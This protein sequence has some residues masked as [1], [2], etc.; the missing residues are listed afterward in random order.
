MGKKAFR[1]EQQ[2]LQDPAIPIN[3]ACLI[4]GDAYSWEYVEKLYSMLCR[5]S[6]RLI[7]LHVYTEAHRDVPAPFIKHSLVD[8]NI[9]GP[10]K[11][12][13]YKLQLFNTDF[14]SGPLLYFD[15]DTVLT[16]SIDWIWQLNLRYFWAVR[17]FKYLWRSNSTG[18]NSSVMWWDTRQY[19]FIWENVASQEL[20]SLMLRH[21]GDQ[22]FI[23]EIVPYDQR[24]FFNTDWVKSWRWECLDGGFNFQ[25]R[26]HR[27]PG[28][29]TSIGTDTSIMIFHGKPKPKD[30]LDPV[31]LAHWQ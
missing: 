15:L 22:D 6:T 28:V 13:W 23:S 3:C 24:R 26:K 2:K 31:V 11:S 29:G 1:I 14:Y 12:W 9:S 18:I 25:L 8:W 10:K 5:H 27:T 4:H 16:N 30:T 19:S 7:N 21:H 20:S 17:D